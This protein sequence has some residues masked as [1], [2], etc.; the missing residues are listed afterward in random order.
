M[1][2]MLRKT[3]DGHE[4]GFLEEFIEKKIL[5]LFFVTTVLNTLARGVGRRMRPVPAGEEKKRKDTPHSYAWATV[6]NVLRVFNTHPVKEN[7]G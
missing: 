7:G 5:C 1:D 4:M 6:E 2:V 3:T